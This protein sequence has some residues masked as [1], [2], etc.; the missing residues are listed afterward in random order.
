MD[1]SFSSEFKLGIIAGGQLGKMLAQAASNWNIKTY[2]LDTSDQCPAIDVCSHFVKGDYTKFEDVYNFGKQVDLLTFEI[3]NINTD[4][5]FKLQSEGLSIYPEPQ[6]LDLIKDKAKQKY[7]F[8]THNVVSPSFQVFS[9]SD[10]IKQ[11]IRS[12][13]LKFPLVQKLRTS[14]YDGRGV[15][16]MNDER[17]LHKLL[18]GPCIVEEKIDIDQELAIQVA[19]NANGEI[20][21]FPV[22][23]LVFNP[24]V[25]LVEYLFCPSAQ[26]ENIQAMAQEMA[27][28]IIQNLNMTG[29]LAVEF[30]LDKTGTLYVN[31]IS[32]RA[33]NSGH[34]T[35]ESCVTS[36]YEQHL[37]SIL[38]YPLGSTQLKFPSVMINLL[39]A[40][41]YEGTPLYNGIDKCLAM[42]GAKIHIYGKT[43]TKAHRKMCHATVLAESIEEAKR[44]AL[45]IR[46]LIQITA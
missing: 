23:D 35:I 5:L 39:G 42:P 41:G 26:S 34:H 2:I 11:A 28:R 21:V 45:K 6:V 16:V 8:A 37:R 18:D 33:H 32:P 14:G 24:Q 13:A 27:G 20:S 12:G 40:E 25:N 22:V 3:E 19:R 43:K 1:T 46:E 10:E 4:A 44:K 7:F 31:E 15:A 9:T 36:Q 29:L 38:G 30:F 17:D